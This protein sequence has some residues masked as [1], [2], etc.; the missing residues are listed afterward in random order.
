MLFEEGWIAALHA[1]KVPE[2][3]KL[4]KNIPYPNLRPWRS[5]VK[6]QLEELTGRTLLLQNEEL[7]FILF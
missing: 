7:V 6:K 3:S 1:A 4:M 2:G 5:L